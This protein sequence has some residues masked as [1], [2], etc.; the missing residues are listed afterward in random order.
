MFP[1]GGEQV[2]NAVLRLFLS[3]SLETNGKICLYRV[4]GRKKV[5]TRIIDDDGAQT[6]NYF[7]V[8]RPL[9]LN[10]SILNRVLL[11]VINFERIG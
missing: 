10:Y 6:T 1:I 8:G 5:M 2:L 11:I 4:S 7:R 3:F 9:I